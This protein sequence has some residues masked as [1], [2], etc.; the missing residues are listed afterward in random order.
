MRAAIF[1][2]HAGA[3]THPDIAALFDPLYFVKRVEKNQKT[4]D[5]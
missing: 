1:E 3:T 5:N 4:S 2:M